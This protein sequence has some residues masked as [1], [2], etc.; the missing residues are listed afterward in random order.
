MDTKKSDADK[1]A[2]DGSETPIDNQGESLEYGDANATDSRSSVVSDGESSDDTKTQAS[3]TSKLPKKRGAF[4][5][6][7]DHFN[8][9]LLLFLFVLI[10]AS[11]A[12]V[13]LYFRNRTADVTTPGTITQQ[14]L[15]AET[16]QEL[17]SN[18]IQV[19]DP[20]QV[21]N[22]QSNSV[23]TGAVLVKGELQAAGGLKI[24]S[25]S[26]A[27]PE[28]SVGGSA[29][30]NQ[31]ETNTLGVGGGA[32][33]NELS[34]QRNLSVNGNSTFNGTIT[35]PSLSVGRL[36]LN[37]DLVISRHIVIG[38][39]T[40]GRSNGSALGGGGT[41]SVSG[42]DTAGSISINTGSAP[43]AGCF[44]TINFTNTF[45]GTPHAV[46]TPV[47]SA[48]GGLNYYVNRDA[49]NL[50]VCTVNPAP[51]HSSFGFDYHVFE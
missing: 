50:S 3:E 16:L 29:T 24:G 12:V 22:I 2:D 21:L 48:A 7:W 51:A 28:I 1:P 35:T 38:G 25:G 18:G 13:V 31:L 44:I 47:G 33:V 32:R 36:Q 45:G 17:A 37:G 42:S 23:F 15:P 11:I 9:Y 19:G 5:R 34:V 27:I 39:A 4:R 14:N 40:P 46:V 30:I 6:F 41:T 8:V 43:A 49:G 10:I 26:L 20:K